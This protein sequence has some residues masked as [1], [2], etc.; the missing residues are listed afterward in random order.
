MVNQRERRTKPEIEALCLEALR[1]RLG[2]HDISY[3]RVRP[4]SGPKSWTWELD[5][6]GPDAGEKALADAIDEV[7][8]L[9]IS[10]I[11]ARRPEAQNDRH[12]THPP[13]PRSAPARGEA[14]VDLEHLAGAAMA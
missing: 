8:A 9:H 5:E 10:M 14:T 2:L 11:C 3:V 13:F 7:A 4:Y 12:L 6:V 1:K